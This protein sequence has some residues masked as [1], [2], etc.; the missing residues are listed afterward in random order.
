MREREEGRVGTFHVGHV[1]YGLI[2][3]SDGQG[4][5]G[6]E[7]ALLHSQGLCHV[8]QVTVF[9]GGGRE[10]GGNYLRDVDIHTYTT[11]QPIYASMLFQTLPP[12]PPLKLTLAPC[13]SAS[14]FLTTCP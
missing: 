5:G 3:A 11:D 7:E 9:G 1:D 14:S 4:L 8:T 13:T 12:S 2:D 10:G 6:H